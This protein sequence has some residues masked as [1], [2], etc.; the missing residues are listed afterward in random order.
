MSRCRRHPLFTYE[1]P[2]CVH[3]K[4]PVD[5]LVRL[6]KDW[7]IDGVT[8]SSGDDVS[9]RFLA[10]DN[11]VA[12]RPLTLL[13]G[14]EV[15]FDGAYISGTDGC[16]PGLG[17]ID[18]GAYVCQWNAYQARDWETVRTEQD[19]LAKLM[20]IATATSGVTGYGAGVGSFKTA[21]A[22][23]GIFSSNRMP[24]PVVA[25]SGEKITMIE[26]ILRENDIL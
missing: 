16:D 24:D 1:I 18:P 26:K 20:R 13:T 15:V 3:V 23:M 25:L 19:R 4:L 8:D 11:A 14:H 7:V 6:G 21:L 17:N 22:L 5:M 2:V 10:Q 12:G 9:F